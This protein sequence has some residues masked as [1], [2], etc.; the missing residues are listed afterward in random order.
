MGL[1][2]YNR[3]QVHLRKISEYVKHIESLEKRLQA[4][5]LNTK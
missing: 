4:L 2:E 1:S 3:Q 5:E